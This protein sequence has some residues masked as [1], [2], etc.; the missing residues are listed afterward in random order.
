[1]DENEKETINSIFRL[2]RPNANVREII[3]FINELVALK[4]VW[5]NEITL[6]NI[7]IFILKKEKLLEQPITQI[8]SGDYLSEISK[9]I[10]N[11]LNLQRQMSALVY[12]IEVDHARQIPLTKYIENCIKS[13]VGYKIGRAH[14]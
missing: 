8:L 1:M 13:E 7:S 10:K 5:G 2:L 9:T 6:L 11:D 14:V 4:S 3:S 12:G